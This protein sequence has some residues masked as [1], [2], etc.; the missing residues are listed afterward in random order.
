[1]EILAGKGLFLEVVVLAVKTVKGTGMVKDSQVLVSVFRA[2][3][4]GIARISTARAR[5]AHK[6]SHTIG[7]KGIVIKGEFSLVGPASL[8]LPVPDVTEP[9]KT[10][11]AF[12]NLASVNTKR[13]ADTLWIAGR[14]H[15]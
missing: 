5:R 6:T 7:W 3:C 2:F 10:C 4:I 11:P 15:R 9:A 8:Q 1:V 13:T 12:W 14:L